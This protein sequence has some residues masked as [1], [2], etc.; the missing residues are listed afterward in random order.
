[1]T[2]GRPRI[3]LRLSV[4]Q[5]DQLKQIAAERGVSVSDI[6]RDL[7]ESFLTENE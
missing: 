7:I 2:K 3:T 4:D 1:M 5:I 6:I